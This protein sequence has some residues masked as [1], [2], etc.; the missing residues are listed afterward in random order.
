[1]RLRLA[2]WDENAVRDAADYVMFLRDAL[3]DVQGVQL[4]FQYSN[5]DTGW[6]ISSHLDTLPKFPISTSIPQN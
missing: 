5:K 6:K 1:M 2:N 4:F 3:V